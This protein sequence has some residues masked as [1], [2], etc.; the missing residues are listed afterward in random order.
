MIISRISFQ[1]ILTN[2]G[3]QSVVFPTIKETKFAEVLDQDNLSQTSNYSEL[4]SP[5]S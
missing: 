4:D 5:V 3:N 2:Y 1:H